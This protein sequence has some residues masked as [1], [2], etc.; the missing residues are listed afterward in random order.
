MKHARTSTALLGA[1]VS[2]LCMSC[3]T[4]PSFPR[5]TIDAS[6]FKTLSL[7]RTF[8]LPAQGGAP[9]VPLRHGD[10]VSAFV[11]LAGD[12]YLV[13][14]EIQSDS[15]KWRRRA[16]GFCA[17]GDVQT[18]LPIRQL[19]HLERDMLRD[20][21][22]HLTVRPMYPVLFVFPLSTVFEAIID[23][24]QGCKPANSVYI[25]DVGYS[26]SSAENRCRTIDPVE[27]DRIVQ[28]LDSFR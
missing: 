20:A 16:L 10:L 23:G 9:F 7:V 22:G 17:G 15:E 27:Y 25:D 21:L 8:S 28:V 24:G 11:E 4:C 18:Y 6:G 19:S 5:Q 12:E 2:L 13:Q 26:Y 14:I 1:G 3:G